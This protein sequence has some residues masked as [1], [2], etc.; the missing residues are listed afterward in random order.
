MLVILSF[1]DILPI[2]HYSVHYS[3]HYSAVHASFEYSRKIEDI[4]ETEEGCTHVASRAHAGVINLVAEETSPTLEESTYIAFSRLHTRRYPQHRLQQ[5]VPYEASVEQFSPSEEELEEFVPV[6]FS[7]P[8]VPVRFSSP[9]VPVK[10]SSPRVP[11]KLS[12]PFSPVKVPSTLVQ[13]SLSYS[14]SRDSVPK[15][16]AAV[17]KPSSTTTT[18]SRLVAAFVRCALILVLPLLLFWFVLSHSHLWF[19]THPIYSS[20]LFREVRSPVFGFYDPPTALYTFGPVRHRHRSFL[21]PRRKNMS[22]Q[23]ES[24]K[25]TVPVESS[26]PEVLDDLCRTLKTLDL[27]KPELS[28]FHPTTESPSFQKSVQVISSA[29]HFSTDNNKQ[30]CERGSE[31]RDATGK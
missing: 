30:C 27:N 23:S 18:S 19:Q 2:R 14:F 29:T 26:S 22:Q 20:H 31:G 24:S 4:L 3:R 11:V 21:C 17:P 10:F 5:P 15:S 1:F 28:P 8:R 13:E 6:K 7:S 9:R 12:S 16:P 25:Q